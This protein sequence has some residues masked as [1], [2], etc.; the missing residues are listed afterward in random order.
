MTKLEK[1]RIRLC[2]EKI[3]VE[4][5]DTFNLDF[6]RLKAA[7][8]STSETELLAWIFALTSVGLRGI[9][10]VT[11]NPELLYEEADEFDKFEAYYLRCC[12]EFGDI[13]IG[14]VCKPEKIRK[15]VEGS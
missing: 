8:D 15:G 4:L 14:R 3:C 9:D 13:L 1:K 10:Q 7:L 5:S 12:E 11:K 2:G 6:P